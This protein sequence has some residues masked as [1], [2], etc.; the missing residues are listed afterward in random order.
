MIANCLGSDGMP[1]CFFKGFNDAYDASLS[2]EDLT[3]FQEAMSPCIN[4]DASCSD[5]VIVI[6]L[7]GEGVPS[8]L[9]W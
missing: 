8:H 7:S 3:T 2:P 1:R 9:L 6:H 4:Q 5:K